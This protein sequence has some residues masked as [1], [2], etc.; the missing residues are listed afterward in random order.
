MSVTRVAARRSRSPNAHCRGSEADKR[1]EDHF[2]GGLHNGGSQR[3]G[4]DLLR[5]SRDLFRGVREFGAQR[6]QHSKLPGRG[7]M[8]AG[9]CGSQNTTD[10]KAEFPANLRR[11]IDEA[12]A[13]GAHPVLLTPL[14]RRQFV[15]GRLQ[16]DLAPWAEAVAKVAAEKHVP[17]V[18]LNALSAKAVEALGPTNANNLAQMPPSPEVAA[19]A[20]SGTTIP[21]Q[22]GVAPSTPN[23]TDTVVQKSDRTAVAPMG[24]VSKAFDYTHLG[25]EGADY[26]ATTVT[27]E[28]AAKVPALRQYL[29]P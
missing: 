18:D 8:E 21:A 17:L 2:G 7:V 11:Y 25:R 23:A 22:T 26:F 10:L 29:V 28:L 5:V 6:S 12:L 16:N 1:G 27:D 4:W 9:A 13:A 19:A 14:T 20:A 15:A 24:K 3:V